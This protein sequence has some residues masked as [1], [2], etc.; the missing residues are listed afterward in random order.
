MNKTWK[1]SEILS[2]S[3]LQNKRARSP[4]N[5]KS[6]GDWSSGKEVS[7]GLSHRTLAA[8]TRSC[9]FEL[10]GKEMGHEESCR[11][12][13]SL[14]KWEEGPWRH[15]R[16]HPG[17]DLGLSRSDRLQQGLQYRSCPADGTAWVASLPGARVTQPPWWGWKAEQ[18]AKQV[19]CPALR[20]HGVSFA[21]FGLTWKLSPL[22]SF[23][24]L[25]FEIEISVLCLSH[26]CNLEYITCLVLLAHNWRGILS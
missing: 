2:L 13:L 16:D 24:H 4:D 9:Q 14:Q 22:S 10:R 8:P 18:Q 11:C 21:S 15:F 12:V 20:A 6:I 26:H 5:T 23:T 7:A 19:Y 25:S 17:P 1:I 3:I